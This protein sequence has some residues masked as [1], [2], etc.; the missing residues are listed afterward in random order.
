MCF[1]KRTRKKL[2]EFEKKKII[3]LT[4]EELKSHE[5]ARICYICWKCFL[6]KLAEDINHRKVRN[7]CHYTRNY[8]GAA[9]SICNLKFNVPNEIPVVFH[10][11]SN[12][13]YHLIIKELVKEFDG[14]FDCLGENK[15]KYW[16]FSDPI[17]KEITKIDKNGNETPET[18]S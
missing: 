18:I 15:E 3:P 6:K 1:F 8:R 11:G 13:D 7:H 5:D 4:N 9:Y 2:I 12:Y 10:N 14:Q 17:K 16:T